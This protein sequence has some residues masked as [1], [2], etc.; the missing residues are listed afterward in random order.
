MRI[1]DWSS[2]VCSSDLALTSK[3]FLAIRGI[4]NGT[5][6]PTNPAGLDFSLG[7]LY[8]PDVYANTT[9]PG[10]P[11]TVNT[12][13]TPSYFTSEL[14]IQGQIEHNFGP[15]SLPVS[16]QSQKIKL[17]ARSDEHT[18]ELQSL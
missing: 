6:T 1:S 11:R 14:T 2:D 10:D 3:E 13:Y 18:S 5:V 9:I 16:G 8:G 4:P 15:V 7:S 17:E 12:A